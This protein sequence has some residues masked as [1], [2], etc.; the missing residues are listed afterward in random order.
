MRDTAGHRPTRG[1]NRF[2]PAPGTGRGDRGHDLHGMRPAPGTACC[3]RA[4]RPD[5]TANGPNPRGN[6]CGTR[7]AG[8]HRP[9]TSLSGAPLSRGAPGGRPAARLGSRFGAPS[10]GSSQNLRPGKRVAS[11][12]TPPQPRHT[13]RRCETR[14][15]FRFM[16]PPRA[17]RYTPATIQ[18]TP[19]V[20]RDRDGSTCT[21]PAGIRTPA[22]RMYW[23]FDD[24]DVAMK[25]IL[26]ESYRYAPRVTA[27]DPRIE[28]KRNFT[29]V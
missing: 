19:S 10:G 14:S 26:F 3:R 15:A 7:R 2:T 12:A 18:A 23:I 4:D 16:A 29:E 27:N 11:L 1:K 9:I 13:K 8:S 24:T 25:R 17:A 21:E 20:H 28:T 6:Q 22:L 5:R